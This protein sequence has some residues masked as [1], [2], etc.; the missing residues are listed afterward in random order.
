VTVW[1]A[2][3]TCVIL[4]K[5]QTAV[6]MAGIFLCVAGLTLPTLDSADDGEDAQGQVVFLGIMLTFVGTRAHKPPCH[7]ASPLPPSEPSAT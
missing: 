3:F 5:A 7:L 6:K 2:L 1:T 4:R